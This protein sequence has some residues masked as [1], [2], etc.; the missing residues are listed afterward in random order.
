MILPVSVKAHMGRLT[1]C[2]AAR[3]ACIFVFSNNSSTMLGG[4]VLMIPGG[5]YNAPAI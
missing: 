3:S 5:P 1:T 4:S 2:S